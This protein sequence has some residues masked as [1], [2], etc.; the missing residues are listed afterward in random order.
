MRGERRN[1]ARTHNAARR[2]NRSHRRF[3]SS[4]S[5]TSA[6]DHWSR[7]VVD[8]R[9]GVHRRRLLAR[10]AKIQSPLPGQ[11]I[12]QVYHL[13]LFSFWRLGEP[14]RG[15]VWLAQGNCAPRGGQSSS[16][17]LLQVRLNEPAARYARASAP[18]Q[19]ASVVSTVVC[20]ALLNMWNFVLTPG[21]VTAEGML[22]WQF[23]VGSKN[24]TVYMH[25][26][27][28]CRASAL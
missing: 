12:G 13:I 5:S 21:C 25:V 7:R 10:V 11:E 20:T 2:A 8:R 28:S 15:V 9:N 16:A 27:L 17:A 23:A 4:T 24:A 18:A 3:S 19:R 14:R 6:F 26:N 1:C 22:T